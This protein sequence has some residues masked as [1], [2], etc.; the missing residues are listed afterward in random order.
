VSK[1]SFQYQSYIYKYKY[2]YTYIYIYIYIYIYKQC[3]SDMKV[4]Y[5]PKWVILRANEEWEKV[6][7]LGSLS[8]RGIEP[9]PPVK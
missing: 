6:V 8:T 9:I 2:K 4:L 7:P 3:Y 5:H 1:F